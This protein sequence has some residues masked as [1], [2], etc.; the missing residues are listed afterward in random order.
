MLEPGVSHPLHVSCEETAAV[1]ASHGSNLLGVS[2]SYHL[3]VSLREMF[4]KIGLRVLI[5]FT[6]PADVGPAGV[7]LPVMSPGARKAE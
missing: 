5:F 1:Q 7:L 6:N 2:H 3:R 4:V